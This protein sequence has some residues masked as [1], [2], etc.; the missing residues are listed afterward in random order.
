MF[1]ETII[2]LIEYIFKVITI[3][4]FSICLIKP[5]TNCVKLIFGSL[6]LP[7]FWYV[8]I[9]FEQYFYSSTLGELLFVFFLYYFYS[10][11]GD[12]AKIN[13]LFSF[14]LINAWI[15]FLLAVPFNLF[16][17]QEWYDSLLIAICLQIIAITVSIYIVYKIRKYITIV[18]EDKDNEKKITMLIVVMN[19]ITILYFMYIKYTGQYHSLLILTTF[20]LA[21]FF[22]FMGGLCFYLI[23]FIK[24]KQEIRF[25]NKQLQSTKEYNKIIENNQLKLRQFKHDYKNI[26]TSLNGLVASEQYD[27]LEIKLNQLTQYSKQELKNEKS[28][29]DELINVEHELLKSIL[30][31]KL[32]EM[33]NEQLNFQFSCP[34]KIT[35]IGMHSFDLI[36]VVGILID[37]AREYAMD[38]KGS[39]IEVIV[40]RGDDYIDII[41]ANTFFENHA[42][43][44][45]FKKKG[46]TTKLG[47]KGLGLTKVEEINHQYDNVLVNYHI[48]DYFSVEITILDREGD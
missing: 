27:Q 31:V 33:D 45:R 19:L 2:V 1:T 12:N 18:S 11:E 25:I 36:R 9:V 41:I 29:Y 16:L 43:I 24:S 44:D 14:I 7:I 21:V 10:E 4:I 22:L 26:L 39:E 15:S 17:G 46:Y 35:T 40:N 20:F 47:H 5:N 3:F 48:D 6:F 34:K 38:Y 13:Q 42:S 28:M 23:Q 8:I 37:N 32:I 30:T